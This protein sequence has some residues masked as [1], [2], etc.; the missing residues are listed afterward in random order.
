VV[1][2]VVVIGTG[3]FDFFDPCLQNRHIPVIKKLIAA[4]ISFLKVF[5]SFIGLCRILVWLKCLS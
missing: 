3:T 4:M 2:I 5:R 1:V